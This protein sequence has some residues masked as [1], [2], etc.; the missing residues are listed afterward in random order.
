MVF[1][2]WLPDY[3]A[4]LSITG[5]DGAQLMSDPPV[6]ISGIVQRMGLNSH[7]V[8]SCERHSQGRDR[9]AYGVLAIG[10]TMKLLPN[11][12]RDRVSPAQSNVKQTWSL[13]SLRDHNF[14]HD[15]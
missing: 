11:L 10:L 3:I 12:R 9:I 5:V 8:S 7:R 15:H 4:L 6:P 14:F 2:V 13:D 1:W